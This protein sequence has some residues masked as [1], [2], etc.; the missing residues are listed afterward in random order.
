MRK[1]DEA[2]SDR[3]RSEL[4]SFVE[5]L[6][7]TLKGGECQ[8]PRTLMVA[9]DLYVQMD[10]KERAIELYERAAALAKDRPDLQRRIGRT[11]LDLGLTEKALGPLERA[12]ELEPEAAGHHC[13]L[14]AAYRSQGRWEEASREYREALRLDAD[15]FHARE[16]LAMSLM[17]V[18]NLEEARRELERYLV[19]GLHEDLNVGS[20]VNL[21]VLYFDLG[22]VREARAIFEVLAPF[23]RAV[24]LNDLAV[25][26]WAD[27]KLGDARRGLL[28]AIALEPE[29]EGYRSNLM[30]LEEHERGP[31]TD[32][33]PAREVLSRCLLLD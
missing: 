10:W 15:H 30:L 6:L 28:K 19:E 31:E 16:G 2:E 32:W 1:S 22:L 21:G 4:P 29:V 11:Y 26:N 7:Q 14:G 17:E 12:V 13:E 18:N 27:G 8:D 24:V 5:G 33:V 9:G 20:L 3:E 25:C 23:E